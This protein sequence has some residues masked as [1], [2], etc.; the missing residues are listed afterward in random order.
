MMMISTNWRGERNTFAA[1][2][3]GSVSGEGGLNG[4]FNSNSIADVRSI[5]S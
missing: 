2:Y 4:T 5:V 1:S 3:S